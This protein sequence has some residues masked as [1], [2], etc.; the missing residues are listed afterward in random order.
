MRSLRQLEATVFNRINPAVSFSIRRY[1]LAVAIFV[2]IGVFGVV[3]ML[4]LGVDLLP[5]VNIPV[6]VVVTTFPGATPGV[7]D[8]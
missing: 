8:Q 1:V 5:S 2:A 6:V 4:G 3:S 7:V